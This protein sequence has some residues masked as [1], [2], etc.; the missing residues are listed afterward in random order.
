[1]GNTRNEVKAKKT[2][3]T[4]M[5]VSSD[6][7]NNLIPILSLLSLME[8]KDL[9]HPVKGNFPICVSRHNNSHSGTKFA[10]N[11]FKNLIQSKD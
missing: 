10:L 1:M 9:P 6:T 2:P 4:V 7:K 5:K 11:F 8:A 3:K